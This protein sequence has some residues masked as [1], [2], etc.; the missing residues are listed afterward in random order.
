MALQ[1]K[2][3][4][5]VLLLAVS[6]CSVLAPENNTAKTQSQNLN[7]FPSQWSI[8]GRLSIIN[9]KENWYAKF[10]WL[11]NNADFQI[12]FMGP[13]GETKLLLIKKDQI[14]Q[15]K[16][17]S[18]ERS[19][20]GN[21]EALETL[22]LQE[23][24]WKFPINSLRFWSYGMPNPVVE[25]EIKYDESGYISDLY[26]QLWH[27]QYPKRIQVGEYYLPKK[28]IV[29]EQ[30]LKIKIVISQWDFNSSKQVKKNTG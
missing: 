23:T 27:V 6:A 28:I 10:I 30:N 4:L 8:H 11:Q 16:T 18:Y 14:I 3:F 15:L 19:Y 22:L 9:D 5:F 20:T 26:Q 29:T 1:K 25:T 12:S 24:G 7:N 17:S 13:L 2:L 21:S